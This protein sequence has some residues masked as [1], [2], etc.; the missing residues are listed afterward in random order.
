MSPENHQEEPTGSLDDKLPDHQSWANFIYLWEHPFALE[1]QSLGTIGPKM[2][3]LEPNSPNEIL[4]TRPLIIDFKILLFPTPFT[5]V[6]LD[7]LCFCF[8]RDVLKLS[9]LPTLVFL[10]SFMSRVSA[11]KDTSNSS[12]NVEAE[13]PASSAASWA[14]MEKA[15]IFSYHQHWLVAD[16][17]TKLYCTIPPTVGLPIIFAIT[18][19]FLS[20]VMMKY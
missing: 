16:S 7:N 13:L 12:K 1:I 18:G 8:A 5:C 14:A 17:W 6:C 15:V 4:S 2:W 3:I 9:P 20:K 11:K 19:V 10:T